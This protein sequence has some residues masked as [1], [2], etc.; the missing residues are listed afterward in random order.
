ME[1]RAPRTPAEWAAYFGLRYSVLRAP[2]GQPEGSE[3]D[4]LDDPHTAPLGHA[5]VAHRAAFGAGSRVLAV[6]RVQQVDDAT[7][8]VRY[9]ASAP[10]ARGQGAGLAVLRSLEEAVQQWG[11]NRVILQ[12]RENA[13]GFYERA[14]YRVVEPT[15]LLF[16]EIQ[17]YLMQRELAGVAPR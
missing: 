7:G 6:G 12:A 4:D 13:V 1:L 2:W 3:R 5:T 15:F 17:H 14:G 11:L 9:M 8:Q 16:G 10:E